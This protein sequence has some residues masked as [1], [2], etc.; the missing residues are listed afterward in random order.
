[1]L[2]LGM[3]M[4]DFNKKLKSIKHYMQVT[5]IRLIQLWQ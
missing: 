1:M 2:N 5:T 3:G 4:N